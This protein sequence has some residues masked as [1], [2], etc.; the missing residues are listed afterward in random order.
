[1]ELQL[2]RRCRRGMVVG[3]PLEETE[4]VDRAQRAARQRRPEDAAPSPETHVFGLES[5]SL[6]MDGVNRLCEEHRHV[7]SCR[8]FLGLNEHE[9]A[10]A[11]GI[12]RGTVR[13]RLSRALERL[14]EE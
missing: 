11:L 4:L 7:V 1:M 3:R 14:R 2:A 8:Y 6:L 12:R 10:A 9:T 13:S 5:R